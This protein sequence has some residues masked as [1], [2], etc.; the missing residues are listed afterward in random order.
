M[1]TGL[2]GALS[3]A[4]AGIVPVSSAYAAAE[5]VAMPD[6][7]AG[8]T[9]F[10]FVTRTGSATPAL[11]SGWTN[12]ANGN[13]A[14][15][16]GNWSGRIASKVA[17]SSSETVGTWATAEH[18]L[19]LVYRNVTAVGAVTTQIGAANKTVSYPA[20]TLQ[21]TNGRSLV[22]R[23]SRGGGAASL[24]SDLLTAAP[25]AGYAIRAGNNWILAQDTAGPTATNPVVQTQVTLDTNYWWA[26]TVELR[27]EVL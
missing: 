20:A 27:T 8:D 13:R 4:V 10:V 25:I 6:H 12:V 3:P 24:T 17:A 16:T 26:V 23:F 9:I 1:P 7:Q 2:V 19:V 14:V 15:G 22:V 18:I 11:Q 21:A 5:T